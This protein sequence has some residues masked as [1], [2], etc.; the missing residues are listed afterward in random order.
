M[1]KRDS[2]LESAPGM[3]ISISHWPPGPIIPLF[4]TLRKPS[5]ATA[6]RHISQA[7][8]CRVDAWRPRGHIPQPHS[9][10]PVR[11]SG[12]HG[13]GRSQNCPPRQHHQGPNAQD[14]PN[15]EP[16]PA[17]VLGPLLFPSGCGLLSLFLLSHKLFRMAL[18]LRPDLM[19]LTCSRT[20]TGRTQGP[21]IL[22]KLRT[23]EAA[24]L[25]ATPR[26]EPSAPH[27]SDASAG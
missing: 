20:S 16:Q 7:A 12:K 11:L 24:S 25:R 13:L 4:E 18:S 17:L 8:G 1:Q 23:H 27:T 19:R 21:A 5:A 14:F 15:S 10:A 3:G 9:R 2:V 22:S 26:E 6:G